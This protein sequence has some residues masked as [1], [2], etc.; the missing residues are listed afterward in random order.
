MGDIVIRALAAEDF[1]G[2]R[3]VDELT[4]RQY[5]DATWDQLPEE[6]KEERLVSR[7]SDFAIYLT[8]GYCFVATINNEVV[9]F[10]FAYETLPFGG[11]IQINYVGISP[12][13]QGQGI[14]LH[15]YSKLIEEARSKGITS[16]TA[17]I[18]LDNPHS[19]R[20]HQKAGFVLQDRKEAT[21]R[22]P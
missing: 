12:A 19:M 4:Q 15:L 1:A 6:D 5:L 21:L 22:L 17:L 18:N 7:S 8:T 11:R 13:Y 3:Q 9:A 16:I 10:L 2:V 20:L 14:G